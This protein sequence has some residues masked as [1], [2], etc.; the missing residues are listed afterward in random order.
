MEDGI[1]KLDSEKGIQL[2]LTSDKFHK[3][4]YL[5]KRGDRIYISFIM[6]NPKEEGK[7][8]VSKLF[9]RIE[10]LGYKVAVPTPMGK[11]QLILI[12]KGFKPTKEWDETFESNVEVWVKEVSLGAD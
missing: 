9:N 1:I 3:G 5:W 6:S 10:E 4:T 7:G 11:M 12:K 8:N 2:G